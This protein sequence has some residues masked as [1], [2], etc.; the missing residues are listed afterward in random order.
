M[1]KDMIPFFFGFFTPSMFTLY[2]QVIPPGNCFPASYS[3]LL[4]MPSVAVFPLF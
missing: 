3:R 4:E 1:D 2:E